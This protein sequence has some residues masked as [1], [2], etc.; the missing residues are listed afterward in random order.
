MKR[1]ARFSL[2]TKPIGHEAMTMTAPEHLAV[3][4]TAGLTF[5]AQ[6]AEMAAACSVR[7]ER[8]VSERR[9]QPMPKPS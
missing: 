7:P 6:A 4:L 8:S 1:V 3:A 9:R 5:P 2:Q